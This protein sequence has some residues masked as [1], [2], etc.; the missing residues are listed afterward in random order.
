MSETPLGMREITAAALLFASSSCAPASITAG[1][2][3]RLASAD[4]LFEPLS[5]AREEWDGD[6]KGL[7][8]A[9]PQSDI[10]PFHASCTPEKK[11]LIRLEVKPKGD[12]GQKTSITFVSGKERVS[13]DAVVADGMNDNETELLSRSRR[14]CSTC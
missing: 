12:P 9:V 14:S 7:F 2:Q 3:P 5:E 11:A 10:I 13:Y 6:A 4:A 8:Y 1:Q